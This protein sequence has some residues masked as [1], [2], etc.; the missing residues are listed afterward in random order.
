MKVSKERQIELLERSLRE[1][2][3]STNCEYYKT[4]K[5]LIEKGYIM[6]SFLIA[7]FI[8]RVKEYYTSEKYQPMY[9]EKHPYG[10]HTLIPALFAILDEIGDKIVNEVD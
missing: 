2:F 9:D 7:D 10:K 3:E 1:E 6:K 8:E 5:N 4:A